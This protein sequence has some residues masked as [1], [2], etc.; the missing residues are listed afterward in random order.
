MNG[1]ARLKSLHPGIT[2]DDVI[3]NTGFRVEMTADV[4]ATPA[5][6]D[7]ELFVLRTRID[8]NGALRGQPRAVHP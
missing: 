1:R 2:V 6:T 7:E 4:G 5:P 3:S 8:R